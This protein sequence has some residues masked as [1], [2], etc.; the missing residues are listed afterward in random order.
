[1]KSI[2]LFI[3]VRFNVCQ[4][5]TLFESIKQS[6][7][8]ESAIH[9]ISIFL[10][11]DLET[12]YLRLNLQS[13]QTPWYLLPIMK[14]NKQELMQVSESV[15]YLY[16]VWFEWLSTF[17]TEHQNC[18]QY[19]YEIHNLDKV[20]TSIVNNKIVVLFELHSNINC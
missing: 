5:M 7:Q 19:V 20:H 16:L 4:S 2:L 9:C 3:F 14:T 12:D 6:F 8:D 17:F 10:S 11:N 15:M 13:I 18:K 1:M